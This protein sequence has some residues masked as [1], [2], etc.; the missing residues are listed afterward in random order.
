M[1][2]G[3]T[4]IQKIFALV[5]SATGHDLSH[6][7]QTTIRRRIERRMAIHQI[8]PTSGGFGLL[9]GTLVQY[10]PEKYAPECAD[11]HKANGKMVEQ[12]NVISKDVA[13]IG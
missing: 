1:R 10:L 9:G 12:Y 2:S 6:C 11:C 8:I 7:K 5:R 4:Y 13:D 3:M